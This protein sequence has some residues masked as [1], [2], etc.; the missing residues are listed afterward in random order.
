MICGDFFYYESFIVI[1]LNFKAMPGNF[2]VPFVA[3][4]G[5]CAQALFIIYLL[6]FV[7]QRIES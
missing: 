5:N 4:N 2:Q 3:L 6:L 1:A 7:I